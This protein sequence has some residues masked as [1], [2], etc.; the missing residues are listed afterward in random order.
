MKHMLLLIVLFLALSACAKPS[1][2]YPNNGWIPLEVQQERIA[3]INAGLET[4]DPREDLTSTYTGTRPPEG[5]DGPRGVYIPRRS[6]TTY[7]YSSRRYTRC[8]S[9]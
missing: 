1:V 9:Y 6:V 2:P 7:C 3:R 4:Y 8:S 5:A